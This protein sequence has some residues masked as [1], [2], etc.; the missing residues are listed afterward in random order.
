MYVKSLNEDKLLI[1]V[2]IS[3]KKFANKCKVK[4]S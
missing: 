1:N 3:N 4:I 2:E